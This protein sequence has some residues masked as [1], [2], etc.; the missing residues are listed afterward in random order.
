M[1]KTGI[2]LA[3]S[4]ISCA[5]VG[6]CGGRIFE[7]DPSGELIPGTSVMFRVIGTTPSMVAGLTL[8]Y[9][10]RDPAAP[11][12][13]SVPSPAVMVTETLSFQGAEKTQLKYPLASGGTYTCIAQTDIMEADNITNVL[14]LNTPAGSPVSLELIGFSCIGTSRA[15]KLYGTIKIVYTKA[16]NIISWPWTVPVVSGDYYFYLMLGQALIYAHK[17]TID[18]T[19]YVVVSPIDVVVVVREYTTDTLVAGAAIT[20]DG[21]YKGVTDTN[22]RINI[23]SMAVG[24]HVI[25]ITKAGYVNTDLDELENDSFVV[26]A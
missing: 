13:A 3:F 17:I 24:R 25:K 2:Q 10:G 26:G 15:V 4:D 6:E 12:V 11:T 14:T 1:A 7:V 8:K 18:A 20:V 22:G 19:D 9:G 16:G 5:G 21:K 23:G